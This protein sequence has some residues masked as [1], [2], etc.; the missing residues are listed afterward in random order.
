MNRL[1]RAISAIHVLDE[2]AGRNTL[3]NKLHP[4][5]KLGAVMCFILTVLSFDKYA[6]S[7][8]VAMGIYPVFLYQLADLSLCEGIKRFRTVAFLLIGLGLANVYFD[9]AVLLNIGGIAVSGGWV[10]LFVLLLKGLWSF[11]AVYFLTA[12]TGMEQICYALQL[13]HLPKVMVVVLL[14]TYRYLILLLQEGS[15]MSAAYA[16]RAPYSKGIASNAWG[17]LVGQL[18][19]RSI[20]RAQTVY[21]S[22]ALR[23][24]DGTFYLQRAADGKGA[25]AFVLLSLGFCLVF[26]LLPVFAILGSLL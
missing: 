13:L 8:V 5:A 4:L 11:L 18:L 22:M 1:E 20:D 16:L 24:F 17:T 15:R 14:L 21:E 12:T 25:L 10:S 7:G 26:R 9:T 23:G 2:L 19:L 3:V 6:L